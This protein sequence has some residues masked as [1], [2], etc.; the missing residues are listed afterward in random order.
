VRVWSRAARADRSLLSPPTLVA[1]VASDALLTREETFGPLA[2]VI[3]FK[4]YDQAIARAN[5]TPVR[6]GGLCLLDAR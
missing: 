1:D 3:P 4:T 6:S 2:G 5:D